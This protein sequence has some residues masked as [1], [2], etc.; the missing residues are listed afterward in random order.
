M[1]WE[2]NVPGVKPRLRM[3]EMVENGEEEAGLMPHGVTGEES[4]GSTPFQVTFV[5][6][7]SL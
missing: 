1:I 7:F 2:Q 6:N 3:F 5:A 4:V